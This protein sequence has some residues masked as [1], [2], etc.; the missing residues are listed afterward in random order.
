MYATEECFAPH[1]C[2]SLSFLEKKYYVHSINIVDGQFIP[3]LITPS[4]C[5]PPVIVDIVVLLKET[6]QACALARCA[7]TCTLH[8]TS[9]RVDSLRRPPS[10]LW[11]GQKAK[12]GVQARV[13]A[14]RPLDSLRRPPARATSNSAGTLHSRWTDVGDGT[15][16]TAVERCLLVT[17]WWA[18]SAQDVPMKRILAHSHAAA[19]R[20]MTF[21][22]EEGKA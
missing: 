1:P 4:N 10:R 9:P 12:P 5:G 6:T 13:Q 7:P 15:W 16:K 21:T 11:A 18:G 3:S 14:G 22:F 20:N 2:H 17:G 8:H 19:S